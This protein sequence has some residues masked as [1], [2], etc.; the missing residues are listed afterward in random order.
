MTKTRGFAGVLMTPD[1]PRND[2]GRAILT[3][4]S[5]RMPLLGWMLGGSISLL[6]WSAIGLG[7]W[8]ILIRS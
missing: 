4:R 2:F 6:L 1:W 7:T 8:A 5:Q 3:P